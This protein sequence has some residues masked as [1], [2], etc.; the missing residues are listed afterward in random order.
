MLICSLSYL[1]RPL[2][3]PFPSYCS[4]RHLPSD[5]LR[6]S[7]IDVTS[8]LVKSTA[9]RY[10]VAN[11]PWLAGSGLT[12]FLDIIGQFFFLFFFFFF[13]FLVPLSRS[14]DVLRSRLRWIRVQ[15][16]CLYIYVY[17]E[18]FAAFNTNAS[19][20]SIYFCLITSIPPSLS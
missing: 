9:E 4:P 15:R 2:L 16:L 1:F 19:L 10:L 5:S 20:L 13:F 3:I 7:P 12:I 17:M 11:L 6:F 18:V 14:L 8:I